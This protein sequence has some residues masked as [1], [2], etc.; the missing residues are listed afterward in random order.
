MK[1]TVNSLQSALLEMLRWFDGVCRKNGLRYYALGGTLLGAVRH[2]GFIPWDDDIDVGMPR[3]D[4]ER[5]CA[6][7]EDKQGRYVLET[8]FSGAPDF[9]YAYAKLYDTATTLTEKRRKPIKRG[10][11]IDVFPL[12]GV[13]NS[14]EESRRH[15]K[16]VRRIFNLHVTVTTS[17]RKGRHFL[18][19]AAV[20][21]VHCIPSFMLNKEKLA[22]KLHKVCRRYDFDTSA[23]ISTWGEREMMPRR[24]FGDP[25]PY[26]FEDMQI[27][28]AAQYD[29]YLK[30]LYGD[31]EK[32]PPEE[33]RV[34]HHMFLEV[35]LER[36]YLQYD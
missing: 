21:F 17:C 2:Q 22:E 10:V 25:T 19:N 4:Y 28:G 24:I 3:A 1:T 14:E 27:Y 15:Y 33:K 23:Y 35:D 18:K 32:L 34:S 12:D 30:H 6:L 31:W 16:R 26:T 11:F 36:S 8:P 20:V 13:G 7:L 29:D 9:C 5:L